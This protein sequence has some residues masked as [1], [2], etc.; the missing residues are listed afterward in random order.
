MINQARRPSKIINSGIY[1][2]SKAGVAQVSFQNL[3]T[4]TME[5]FDFEALYPILFNNFDQER[6]EKLVHY[7]IDGSL[8]MVDFDKEKAFRL[9]DKEV[10]Y[11]NLFWKTAG[12]RSAVINERAEQEFELSNEPED[13]N[14]RILTKFKSEEI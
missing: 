11:L 6:V 10:N 4:K 7:I 1:L 2:I 12:T 8:I 5:F 3:V 9:K 14:T 13:I